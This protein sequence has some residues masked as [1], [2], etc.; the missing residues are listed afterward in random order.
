MGREQELDQDE[1]WEICEALADALNQ[2]IGIMGADIAN[3]CAICL[4]LLDALRF[5]NWT[6]A[7]YILASLESNL[8]GYD[9]KASEIWASWLK[10][11]ETYIITRRLLG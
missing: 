7:D 6:D 2:K 9:P 10:S 3:Q 1:Y 8:A 5:E 4:S 11:V